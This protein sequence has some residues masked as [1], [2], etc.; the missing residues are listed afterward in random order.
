MYRIRRLNMS[1]GRGTP[2]RAAVWALVAAALVPYIYLYISKYPTF[3]FVFHGALIPTGDDYPI[4][5]YYALKFCRDPASILGGQ[6][7]GLVQI[8]ASFSCN[9]WGAATSLSIAALLLVPLGIAAWGLVYRALGA[10]K[11]AWALSALAVLTQPRI[12]QSIQDGQLPEKYVLLVIMPLSVY[13]WLK[14]KKALGGAVAG[15]AAWTSYMG[16]S[17]VALFALAT[18]S[19][20][21]MAAALAVAAAGLPR[22]LG[23]F[24][25]AAEAAGSPVI[26]DYTSPLKASFYAYFNPAALLLLL[27]V[28]MWLASKRPRSLP[29]FAAAVALWAAAFVVTP[30]NERFVRA[31][32]FL[33][34]ASV[35]AMAQEKSRKALAAT[36]VI[37]AAGPAAAG[38][39]WAA[40][41]FVSVPY[42]GQLI[43]YGLFQPSVRVLP[44]KFE[45]YAQVAK[46]LPPGANVTVA[47]QLDLWLLPYLYQT[48]PD[49]HVAVVLC[50]QE[51]E[52]LRVVSGLAPNSWYLPCYSG[53]PAGPCNVTLIK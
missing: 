5:V 3:F 11:Q 8:A 32:A 23:A 40:A 28:G 18:L 2:T 12:L 10:G 51:L 14:G 48:R 25:T 16:S 15:L 38:W 6:Y 26:L 31:A 20:A 22:V 39:A 34:A 7:P 30:L 50:P 36:A 19:P 37:I 41:H 47:W 13:L 49:V 33:L 42:G 1:R 43:Q 9:I 4:H 24:T 17:Y 29:L 44:C 52:G 35:L 27:A 21:Y 53:W 45:A 46:E